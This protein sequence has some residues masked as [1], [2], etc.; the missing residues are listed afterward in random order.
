MRYRRLAAFS[1]AV[2]L[3]C[4]VQLMRPDACPPL[5][6]Q[7]ES[8]GHTATTVILLVLSVVAVGV[9]YI[10]SAC[11]TLLYVLVPRR[12]LAAGQQSC[13]RTLPSAD[14]NTR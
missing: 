13:W 5:P 6:A 8:G 9:V 3:C 11:S 4:I 1:R 7:V 2:L 12:R 14:A 10:I